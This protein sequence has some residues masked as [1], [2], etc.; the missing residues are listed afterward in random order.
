MTARG[1]NHLAMAMIADCGHGRGLENPLGVAVSPDGRNVYVADFFGFGVVV[2]TRDAVTGGSRSWR[3][4][5]AVCSAS[6]ASGARYVG[7]SARRVPSRS[8]RT[9]ERSM[10]RPAAEFRLSGATRSRVR[11]RPCAGRGAC[12]SAWSRRVRP[13][14]RA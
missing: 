8:R 7:R 11:L 6:R 10:S 12:D 5:G 4:R 9:A 2:L 3:D 14:P 13:R 1:I